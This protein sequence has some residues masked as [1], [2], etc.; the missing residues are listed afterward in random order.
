MTITS[1]DRALFNAIVFGLITTPTFAILSILPE[2]WGYLWPECQSLLHQ[3][4]V[5]RI[6]IQWSWSLL[7][8]SIP[9]YNASCIWA[10]T[11]SILLTHWL[12]IYPH[13]ISPC[14]VFGNADTASVIPDDCHMIHRVKMNKMPKSASI[15]GFPGIVW[16][17]WSPNS[18][19]I[20]IWAEAQ[21][22]IMMVLRS[23]ML[24]LFFGKNIP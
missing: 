19:P 23:S 14:I 2:I 8:K 11:T 13:L 7:I 22:W 10:Q 4:D 21:I 18:W 12:W 24:V 5:F 3:F 9:Q 20:L 15:C 16:K 1:T 17:V 6:S